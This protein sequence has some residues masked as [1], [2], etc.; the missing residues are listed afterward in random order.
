MLLRCMAVATVALALVSCGGTAKTETSRLP[1]G[2][3]AAE[4]QAIVTQFLRAPSV[5]PPALFHAYRAKESD[6][7]IF[8]THSGPTAVAHAARRLRLGER[9]RLIQL[10]VSPQD[11]NHVRIAFTLTRTSPDFVSRGI[12]NRIARGAGTIDCAHGKI[13]EWSSTGP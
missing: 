9:D 3:T 1:P 6:G 7:R 8:A 4:A 5:A 2:C 10:V 11:I 13:A 12:H